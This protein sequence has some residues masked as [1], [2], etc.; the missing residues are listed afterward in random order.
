MNSFKTQNN[1]AEADAIR[2]KVFLDEQQFS[3]EFDD[4]DD[5]FHYITVTLDKRCVGCVRYQI[6]GD[7]AILGRLA[8]LKEY[9]NRGLG[10]ALV[11]ECEQAIK[12]HQVDEIHLHAQQ[13]KIDFY[14]KLGYEPVGPF[15]MD[16][17]MPHQWMRK[18]VKND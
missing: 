7:K 15:D 9:R 4:S 17:F 1:R 13:S 5:D 6:D 8:V 11:L 18:E 16:E 14:K 2:Q 12:K 10:K 3:Q